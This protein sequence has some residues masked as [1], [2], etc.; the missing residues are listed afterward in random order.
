MF[1]T[2]IFRTTV[3]VLSGFVYTSVYA[4]SHTDFATVIDVDP[5]YETIEYREP[6]QQCHLEERVVKHRS[7]SSATPEIL[8]ALIGG[9]IGNE[10][11]HNKSNKRVGALAGAILGGSIAHDLDRPSHRHSTTKTERVCHTQHKIKEKRELS[12][13]HVTYRYHGR[14]YTTFVDQH[15][16]DKLEVYVDVQPIES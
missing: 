5:I 10:L 7:S 13:Y 14:R 4:E 16:G 11:G 3:L 15:P 2:P 9:A 1:Q 12:G 6:Y 8:G